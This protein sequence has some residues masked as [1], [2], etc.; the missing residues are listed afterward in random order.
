[1]P[2]YA[3]QWTAIQDAKEYGSKI[4][5]FYGIPPTAQEGHPMH[6]LYLFKTGFGGR[7]VHRPGSF[8]IPLKKLYSLYTTAE[9]LRAFYHKTFLKKIRGR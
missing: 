2:A 6:G 5:D 8:D 4:Y 1:M 9:K 3:V 7:E